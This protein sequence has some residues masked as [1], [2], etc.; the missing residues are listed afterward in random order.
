MKKI[1]AI[2]GTRPEAIKMAPVIRALKAR[3]GCNV[4]TCLTGQHRDLASGIL[5]LFDI[6][7]EYNLDVMELDQTLPHVTAKLI[8]KIDELVQAKQPRW[9]IAQG[10]TS[11]V[12]AAALV[13]YYNKIKFGHVEAG[14]RTNDLYSPYPE[15]GNRRV[16]DLLAT[17]AWAPTQAAYNN[18]VKD[19]MAPERISLTGNTVIDALLYIS[20]RCPIPKKLAYLQDKKYALVTVHRRESFGKPLL[21]ICDAIVELSKQHP[22]IGFVYPVHPNPNVQSVVQEQLK[23]FKNI[24]LLE[25]QSYADFVWLMKHSLFIMT[26]SGGLQE[27]APSLKIPVLV[28]RDKTERM[29]GVKAGFSILAG[30]EKDNIVRLTSSLI[31][32]IE[33]HTKTCAGQNPYG[34]GRASDRIAGDILDASNN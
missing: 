16:A 31:S 32:N 28:L 9:V 14:L 30:R 2:I 29:E 21:D 20:E 34:D 33:A 8:L 25:P 18:L 17:K 10:D 27:E 5:D 13:A 12:M 11:S 22:D 26:D 1:L 3:G 15:E 6:T 7:P 19:G 24:H 4:M 23:G